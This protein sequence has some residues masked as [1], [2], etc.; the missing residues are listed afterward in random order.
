M[1]KY[2]RYGLDFGTSNSVIALDCDGT[3]NTFSVDGSN[4]SPE[5]MASLVYITKDR[6]TYVGRE[7]FDTFVEDISGKELKRE[8]VDL[9]IDLELVQEATSVFKVSALMEVDIPGRFFQV[10]KSFLK[11]EHFEETKVFAKSYKLPE[12]VAFILRNMKERA[13][14][15]LGKEVDS[16]LLGRPVVFSKIQSEDRVAEERLRQA[17]QLAGFKEVEFQFEPIAASIA[18]GIGVSSPEKVLVVDFGG[19]TLDTCVVQM[20]EEGNSQG[21]GWG[22][23][24][25]VEGTLIG[26]T[27]FDKVIM[28][29]KL[30]K[31]FG[32][33]AIWGEKK[34]PMPSFLMS[35]ICNHEDTHRLLTRE[36]IDFLDRMMR[37]SKSKKE[38]GALISLIRGNYGWELF[39]EIERAKIEVSDQTNT[40]LNYHR[41]L[42]D[43]EEAISQKEFEEIIEDKLYEA[44]KCVDDTLKGAGLKADDIDVVLQTGGSSLIPAFQKIL[45]RKFAP[46]KIK[47]QEVF[48]SVARGLAIA[49]SNRN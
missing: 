43:I 29:E 18:Y 28:K 36:N 44:E 41:D 39:S 2:L 38:I 4:N 6:E 12:L 19:G 13:D 46:D 1:N 9:G 26:G 23:I 35:E 8:M 47:Y 21:R 20:G 31:H 42:I 49:A 3:I 25:S 27:L 16:V 24:L 30:L 37:L 5:I 40:L 14:G 48:T 33:D 22:D 7:A 10:L 34:L 32:A 17:A 45:K 15:E 11:D